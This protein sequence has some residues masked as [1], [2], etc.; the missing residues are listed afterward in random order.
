MF[1]TRALLAT[2]AT[3]GL[4]T[5][6]Y[7]LSHPGLSQSVPSAITNATQSDKLNLNTASAKELGKVKGL[8]KAKA[9]NIELHRKKNGNFK[10]LDDL[11]LVKGFKKV[12]PE[13][14]KLI[15]DQLRL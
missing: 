14:L 6:G 5:V 9:K 8:S 10:A 11:K 4:M 12:K 7:A 15:Q 3:F 2:V 1:Y 13:T